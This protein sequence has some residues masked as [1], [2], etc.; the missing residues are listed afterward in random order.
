MKVWGG[1]ISESVT[2]PNSTSSAR[3]AVGLRLDIWWRVDAVSSILVAVPILEH[4]TCSS[5]E[6]GVLATAS[7]ANTISGIPPPPRSTFSLYIRIA[8]CGDGLQLA[9]HVRI[10]GAAKLCIDFDKA[11]W[12]RRGRTAARRT[13]LVAAAR[14]PES[15]N[16]QIA[17]WQV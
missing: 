1:I 2:Q 8:I 3:V 5:S 4:G 17:S 6:G 9:L 7:S 10:V 16:L 11:V 12:T 14:A 13:N 15:Q